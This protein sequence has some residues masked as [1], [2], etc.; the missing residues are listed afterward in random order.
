MP[1]I[2]FIIPAVASIATSAIGAHAADSAANQ[3]KQAGQAAAQ[4]FQP[5]IA[6]G[7]SAFNQMAAKYGIAPAPNPNAA[8][9]AM[10]QGAP[11]QPGGYAANVIARVQAQRAQQAAANQP[12]VPNPVT[13]PIADEPPLATIGNYGRGS[14]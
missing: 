5:F 10:A 2:P 12:V 4:T 7:V 6:P 13:Q 14:Y 3:Q 1:A 8:A 11:A 9:S